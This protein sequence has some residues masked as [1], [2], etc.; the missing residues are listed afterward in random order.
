MLLLWRRP[1]ECH[2]NTACSRQQQCGIW[3]RFF[4]KTRG[5]HLFIIM[6]KYRLW[7][8]HYELFKKVNYI[9]Q[10]KIRLEIN[11]LSRSLVFLI[12]F[13]CWQDWNMI[14]DSS[15]TILLLHIKTIISRTILWIITSRRSLYL[16]L[17]T[18]IFEYGGS[19]H[20][21]TH[22]YTRGRI[23]THANSYQYIQKYQWMNNPVLS[24][25]N[26]SIPKTIP[27]FS[28]KK[29]KVRCKILILK[30]QYS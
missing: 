30:I 8:I 2:N 23:C 15:M 12:Y 26:I 21:H 9:Y 11:V 22:R 25:S 18:G 24:P 19:T 13:R 29:E 4:Y 1:D 5:T 14:F 10:D 6:V 3:F 28:K 20:R 16:Y 27:S 17:F 7:R